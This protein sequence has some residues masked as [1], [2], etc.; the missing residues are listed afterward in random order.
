MEVIP[1][2]RL[3]QSISV[4]TP[5]FNEECVIEAFYE[6]TTAVLLATAIPY[7]LI[8]V[9]D[10]SSDSTWS[11]L[12]ALRDKDDRVKI[13]RLSRNYG[14]QRAITCGLDQSKGEVVLLLDADLQDPP[15]LLSEMLERWQ[16]GYYVV[17]GRRR[18]REGEGTTKRLFA[19][20]FYRVLSRLTDTE[21]PPDTGD[22]RLMDRKAVAALGHLRETQRFVRGMVSWIG[23]PQT[24]VYYDRPARHAGETKYPVKKSLLLA[25]DAITSFS[26]VPLRI[27]SILGLC[28][29]VFAFFYIFVVVVLKFMGINVAGYTSL[30]A[31]ILLLGGVQLIVL[32]VI[33]EYVGRIFEQTKQRPLYCVFDV[34]G[35]P[36]LPEL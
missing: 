4:V 24:P 35:E 8:F 5:C 14:H 28:L 2:R 29:S 26:Q 33:G 12:L 36:E 13:I 17:Y 34:Q 21:I 30:M 11:R 22:F 7:E 27:A 6:R 20:T 19:Y 32:G 10:G 16:E 31:T 15:E 1:R 18:A 23:F 25:I 3:P 9:D